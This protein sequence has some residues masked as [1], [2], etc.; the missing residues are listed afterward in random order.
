MRTP[1]PIA[2]SRQRSRKRS[3]WS[4]VSAG[5]AI[6]AELPREAGVEG[7]ERLMGDLPAEQSVGFR[8]DRL[9]VDDALE[10]PG[11]GAVE[12]PLELRGPEDGAAAELRQHG[13]V[14]EPR[15]TGE[16]DAGAVEAAA[17]PVG[18]GERHREWRRLGVG[19]E[20]RQ[21]PK[22][23][24]LGRRGL[25]RPGELRER[26]PVRGALD[27]LGCEDRGGVLPEGA[28]LERRSFVGRRLA[29]EIQAA[30]RARARRVEEVAVAADRVGSL[31]ACSERAA[32]VVVEER[33]ARE[34]DAGAS[35][36]R[37]RGRTPCRSDESVPASG[38]G[39]RRGPA[40][41]STPERT[42]R[43]RRASMTSRRSSSPSFESSAASSSRRSVAA[44]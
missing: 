29:H 1:E 3:A 23:L 20:P 36:P 42:S 38:R 24:A 44:P 40:R 12:E 5:D 28:R 26:P 18:I 4:R 2:S 43:R 17:P 11:G 16:R 32:H 41:R 9:R 25:E 8:V 31:E 19:R 30:R 14:A 21:R 22:P 7:V 10:Q 33:R 34:R 6:G 35:P 37:A 15:P 13:R 27:L 39:R